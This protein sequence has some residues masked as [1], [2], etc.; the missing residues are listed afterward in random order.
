MC[1][2]TKHQEQTG[3]PRLYEM[4]T[5]ASDGLCQVTERYLEVAVHSSLRVDSNR[6]RLLAAH[7]QDG[8]SDIIDLKDHSLIARV[9]VGG[10]V[11]T[12]MDVDS[13]FYYVS[14]Q[15]GERVAVLDARR[16]RK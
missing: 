14:V 12:A 15:P 13:K 5:G 1:P 3:E 11:D 4:E 16:S 9:K 7:V 8:T 6:N 2:I 10:P